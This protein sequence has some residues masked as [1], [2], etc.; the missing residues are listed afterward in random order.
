[1]ERIELKIFALI[2]SIFVLLSNINSSYARYLSESTG[3]ADIDFSTWKVLVNN[4]DIT[5]ST[6]TNMIITP[7][8]ISNSNV[9]NGTLAPGSIGYFDLMIDCSNVETSFNYQISINKTGEISNLKVIGYS[10]NNTSTTPSVSYKNTTNHTYPDTNTISVNK[11]LPTSG[12]F[13]TFYVRIFF[14][15]I[16][17]YNNLNTDINDTSIG[18]KSANNQTINYNISVTLQFRQISS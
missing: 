18:L 11:T 2:I 13:S 15:W 6:V 9:R 4:T 12:T 10:P 16:D 14:Q 7:T 17:N 1:M 8:I 5:N 3:T